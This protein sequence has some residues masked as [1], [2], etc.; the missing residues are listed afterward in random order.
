MNGLKVFNLL[1]GLK[2]LEVK[3]LLEKLKLI[4]ECRFSYLLDLAK[5]AD[6]SLNKSKL[7]KLILDDILSSI[8]M[9]YISPIFIKLLNKN[10][11]NN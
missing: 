5:A 9:F 3:K 7:S 1:Y 8:N 4:P 6:Y 10:I 11:D 2:K